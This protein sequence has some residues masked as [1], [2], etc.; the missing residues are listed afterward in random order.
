MK[1]PA[2]AGLGLAF[3]LTAC[4]GDSEVSTAD[5]VNNAVEANTKQVAEVFDATVD[6]LA[7][8][9]DAAA[10]AATAAIDD[11]NA[12]AALEQLMKDLEDDTE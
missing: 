11:E 5:N 10:D 3:V 7:S 6:E 2:I 12:E 9:V 4:P 8:E 1:L